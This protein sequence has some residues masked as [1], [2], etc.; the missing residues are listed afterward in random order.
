MKLKK[1]ILLFLIMIVFMQF[2][3]NVAFA[4]EDAGYTTQ[5]FDV[6]VRISEDHVFHFT[7]HITVNFEKEE[8]GICR[9]IAKDD[10]SYKIENVHVV[11]HEYEIYDEDTFLIEIG[12]TDTLVSGKQTYTIQYDMVGFK[13]RDRSKDPLYLEILPAEWDSTI[14]KLEVLVK[15]PMTFDTD[16][17]KILSGDNGSDEGLNNIKY[18]FSKNG[19]LMTLSADQLPKGN[20]I[21]LSAELP[22]GY[23]V[24]PKSFDWTMNLAIILLIIGVIGSA[25][26]W[27]NYGRDKKVRKTMEFYPP[28]KI[29]PAEAGYVLTSGSGDEQMSAMMLY[30]AEKEYLTI[31]ENGTGQFT[32]IKKIDKLPETESKYMHTLF[33]GIFS[34]AN[35]INLNKLPDKLETIYHKAQEEL[36]EEFGEKLFTRKSVYAQRFFIL[37]YVLIATVP[38]FITMSIGMNPF[39]GGV[40]NLLFLGLTAFFSIICCI[41]VYDNR[42]IGG[43]KTR[44]GDVIGAFAALGLNLYLNLVTFYVNFE[45]ILFCCLF[46]MLSVLMIVFIAIMQSRTDISTRLL[47]KTLGLRNFIET[48]DS[49]RLRRLSNDNPNYYYS[50]M[51]YAYVFGLAEKWINHFSDHIPVSAPNWYVGNCVNTEDLFWYNQMVARLIDCMDYNIS[52]KFYEEKTRKS[53]VNS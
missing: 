23:W 39:N 45:S 24:N 28:N 36:I 53:H 47:E 5:R 1:E 11:G 16:T 14:E 3:F 12:D 7:E 33:D 46:V 17:F 50:I 30:F 51:S 13:D 31:S 37:Y 38:C 21:T 48:A 43:T 42:H 27:F 29:T 20:R 4:E 52:A 35:E 26:Y 9:Y 2:S 6:K 41:S 15:F 25:I 8:Y 44:V 32:L 10:S 34:S 19:I 49:D 18:D 40:F 22:Q